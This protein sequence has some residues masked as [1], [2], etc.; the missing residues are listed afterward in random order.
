MISVRKPL[1]I[2]RDRLELRR[3]FLDVHTP[4]KHL[5][6]LLLPP[7]E[8]VA[9]LN[10]WI[11]ELIAERKSLSDKIG[12]VGK[13]AG[14]N[15]SY[16]HNTQPLVRRAIRTGNSEKQVARD[17]FLYAGKEMQV[18]MRLLQSMKAPAQTKGEQS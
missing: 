14:K 2:D 8:Q 10:Q 15:L 1:A 4:Q 16:K 7:D 5:H 18:L 9:L 13:C 11:K 3:G 6:E 12:K 17:R